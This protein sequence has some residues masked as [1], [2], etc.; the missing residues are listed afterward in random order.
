M[1][2]CDGKRVNDL[3]AAVGMLA[4]LS[5]THRSF[6]RL[7]R[8]LPIE[9]RPTG[10]VYEMF[11]IDKGQNDAGAM[12]SMA[13]TRDDGRLVQ[14][15]VEAW[16][17]AEVPDN[18]SVNVKAEIDLD[19]RNG[20]DYCVLNEQEKITDPASVA[21]AIDRAAARVTGFPTDDLLT[22]GWEPPDWAGE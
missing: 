12:V 8:Q 6:K 21:G 11:T 4:A 1:D 14:W 10:P 9:T 3:A 22:A 20:D 16:I 15:T 13:A 2:L 19:D 18:W 5:A 17:Y 7:S